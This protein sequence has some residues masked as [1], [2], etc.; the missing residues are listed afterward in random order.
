MHRRLVV[1]M[2]VEDDIGVERQA[3]QG[4]AQL[5]DLVHRP[6]AVQRREQR[7]THQ[8]HILPG[9]AGQP[10][11]KGGGG[12]GG[13]VGVVPV[14]IAVAGKRETADVIIQHRL[15]Q[16]DR[17][18]ARHQHDLAAD[19]AGR[20]QRVETPDQVMGG[21]HARQLVGVQPSLDIG[22]GPGA[23][24]AVAV[25]GHAAAGSGGGGGQRDPG[26]GLVMTALGK[27]RRT[28]AQRHGAVMESV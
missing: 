3:E 2:Q 9:V 22:L 13:E 25:G 19:R 27:G 1:A 20:V 21:Q 28:L 10:A 15:R 16:A 11:G 12:R 26:G 5:A 14:E 6:V 18:G 23:R 8:R 17:I 4:L 24:R 7:R